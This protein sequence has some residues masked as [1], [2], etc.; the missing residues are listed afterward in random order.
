MQEYIRK[1]A[2]SDDLLSE[3][4]GSRNLKM[5]RNERNDHGRTSPHMHMPQTE[6][7][8]LLKVAGKGWTERQHR[9]NNHSGIR[10]GSEQNEDASKDG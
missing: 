6:S 5:R 4:S 1:I 3:F 8:K 10:T 9:G 2:S 7:Q